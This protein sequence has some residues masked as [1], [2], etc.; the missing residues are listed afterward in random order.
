[1][2]SLGWVLGAIVALV[3]AVV[4][5]QVVASESGEVVTIHVVDADGTEHN[6]RIWIVD[7]LGRQWIRGS[8]HEGGW[9]PRAAAHPNI[10]LGRGGETRTYRAVRQTEETV[11]QR[12]NG[13]FAE[14]YGWRDRVISWMIG[15][16]ER[17]GALVLELQP[18]SE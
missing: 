11:R 16:P 17:K 18:R 1:M 9:A 3:V 2:R 15:D 10:R 7:D 8:D 12:I 6:T 4:G 14:K 5:L 13:L